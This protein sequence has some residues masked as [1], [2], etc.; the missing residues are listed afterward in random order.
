MTQGAWSPVD[1]LFALEQFRIKLGLDAMRML[2]AALGAP[3]R[4]W[5]SLHIAGTNGKGSTSA[6]V[7]RA[8][9][10][11]GCRTGR[12]TSPHLHRVEERVAI[13]GRDIS[14]AGFSEALARVFAAADDL[15]A[16]GALPH[17]P[18]F[19]EVSTAAAF[20]AF[21]DAQVEVAVIEVGLGGRYDATN[22]ITPV[23][24][25]ITS[26]AFDHE[27]H[28][29]TTFDAIAREKAGIAKPGVP[30]VVGDVPDEA[31]RAI[32][33]T[34]QAAH[35]PIVSARQGAT[36]DER[37]ADGQHV[38]T[39]TTPAAR[40]GPVRL[41]LAG[42]HQ[43]RNALVAVRLLE[44]WAQAAGRPLAGS[45]VETG[46]ADVR[47]PARLE[48]LHHP[49]HPGRV[50]VD[51][52]HNPAGT[53]ALASYLRM[54]VQGPVVLVTS[55]MADKDLAGVLGPL[56]PFVSHVVATAADTPRAL[57]PDALAADVRRLVPSHVPVLAAPTPADAMALA[58]RTAGA[59]VVLLA[60]SIYLVGPL[61]AA[62]LDAGYRSTR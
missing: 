13:D 61:R 19:F 58:R 45:A 54:A 5:P 3:E 1:R 43:T 11:A 9:R 24:G 2:L 23:A 7:E 10:A 4:Q 44:T 51:A 50:L 57:A 46:L 22:V 17:G 55:V 28:L 6:M 33:E 18:T 29:G 36:V 52:A 37:V 21:A 48:W 56:A 60:G 49:E 12:Y 59:G 15:V 20:L 16:R 40:Y 39:L 38:V 34:A 42:A 47:W 35:A 41:G 30:L 62:L 26:I 53:E 27:R 14:P 8:L 31:W 25:A 32:A